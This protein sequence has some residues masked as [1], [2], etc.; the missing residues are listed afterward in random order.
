VTYLSTYEDGSILRKGMAAL[1]AFVKY[2]SLLG[3][4]KVAVLHVHS[5]SRW[6]FMRKSLLVLPTFLWRK[7]VIFHLHGAEF[8]NVY[9]NELGSVAKAYIRFILSRCTEI[10]VL[11]ERWRAML[12]AIVRHKA[13]RVIMN[14][15]DCTAPAASKEDVANTGTMLFLGELGHRK[16]IFVLLDAVTRLGDKFNWKLLVGGNGDVA[17]VEKRVAEL[18]IG[19]KV[20]LLGW[21]DGP[22]KAALLDAATFLVLP[23]Y[24][25]GLPM[26]MLEAM[27]HGTAVITTPVG[28]IPDLFEDG[29]DG[30]LVPPG[31]AEKL[32][33]AIAYLL[34]NPTIRKQM[35]IEGRRKFEVRF[36]SNVI[37]PQVEEL[38]SD[39]GIYPRTKVQ[40]SN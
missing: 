29:V 17:G 5:A 37:I 34:E 1:T 3:A 22:N 35:G 21:V 31:D 26:S 15:I 33:N 25:E 10:V 6:S 12:E 19:D 23:S 36:S 40:A 13:I 14:P 39:M 2:L 20:R 32:S 7:P 38:Y 18:G 24:A 30:I 4:G 9:E 8:I 11:S 16:G 28:G 27:A